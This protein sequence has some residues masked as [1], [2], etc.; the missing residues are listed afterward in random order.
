MKANKVIHFLERL[1][2]LISLRILHFS[3]LFSLSVLVD[4][5]WKQLSNPLIS[6]HSTF[7]VPSQ[8][9]QGRILSY[10]IPKEKKNM[11]YVNVKCRELTL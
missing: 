2:I 8:E 1:N 9:R 7:M 5:D 10:S 11:R 3:K 6:F 4:V